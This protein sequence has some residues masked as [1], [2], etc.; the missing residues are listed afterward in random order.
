MSDEADDRHLPPAAAPTTVLC[1]PSLE[2]VFYG[3]R[4][5]KSNEPKFGES[6]S[7]HLKAVL[8]YLVVP[9]SATQTL[10]YAFL[11]LQTALCVVTLGEDPRPAR[12]S[13]RHFV[14]FYRS[15]ETTVSLSNHLPGCVIESVF[16]H[17][18]NFFLHHL[19]PPSIGYPIPTQ[20]TG[21]ASM[22]PLVYRVFIAKAERTNRRPRTGP[23]Y[24]VG[25]CDSVYRAHLALL[26][27]ICE[28]HGHT[29]SNVIAHAA[30]NPFS[31]AI[32]E[33][34]RIAG[35]RSGERRRRPWVLA[36]LG[37]SP[38]ALSPFRERIGYLLVGDHYNGGEH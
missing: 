11:V 20:K 17:R 22:T 16:I 13:D 5:N 18:S 31:E 10:S 37:E 24:T 35:L 29:T 30:R 3:A 23:V 28:V 9:P 38:C 1:A 34:I 32:V 27:Q 33:E 26:R 7:S 4:Q 21:D 15:D 12:S 2:N 6:T 14:T 25:S 8:V 19:T 36:P